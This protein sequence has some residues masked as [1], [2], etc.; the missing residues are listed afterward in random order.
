MGGGDRQ[1]ALCVNGVLDVQ[2]V[3]DFLEE[4]PV[5]LDDRWGR[6]HRSI[7]PHRAVAEVADVTHDSSVARVSGLSVPA[8]PAGRAACG[9]RAYQSVIAVT[10]RV[11]L[12]FAA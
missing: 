6:R 1:V 4:V 11:T 8:P 2:F 7:L 12:G 5:R 9:S 3:Q 10:R